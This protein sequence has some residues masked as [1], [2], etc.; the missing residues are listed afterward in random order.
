M[1]TRFRL[2]LDFQAGLVRTVNRLLDVSREMLPPSVSEVLTSL[3][4]NLLS[5]HLHMARQLELT[6]EARSS[7]GDVALNASMGIST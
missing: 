3:I 4:D 6:P 1:T 2:P 7:E 5:D